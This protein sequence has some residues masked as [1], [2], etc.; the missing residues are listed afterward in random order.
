MAKKQTEIKP[1]SEI[2]MAEWA[3]G[4]DINKRRVARYRLL[5]ESFAYSCMERLEESWQKN[6]PR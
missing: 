2:I 1:K 5:I 4:S 3:K 6:K